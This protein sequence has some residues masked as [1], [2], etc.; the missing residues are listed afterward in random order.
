M[1]KILLVLFIVLINHLAYSQSNTEL[2]I[3]QAAIDAGCLKNGKILTT[4]N[5]SKFIYRAT[6]KSGKEVDFLADMSYK[7]RDGSKSGKWSC[8][9]LN[10]R[11]SSSFAKKLTDEFTRGF[12]RG[13]NDKSSKPTSSSNSTTIH[14]C[15]WCSSGFQGGGFLLFG[16]EIEEGGNRWTELGTYY[17]QGDYCSRK[18]ANEAYWSKK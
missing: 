8:S 1:K 9:E 14:K 6:T 7:F 17:R 18:C 3:L 16:K 10:E 2:Q 12:I 4:T 11:L 15:G 5:R 13:L